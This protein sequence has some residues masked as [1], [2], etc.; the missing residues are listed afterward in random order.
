MFRR[1]Y[2]PKYEDGELKSRTNRQLEELSKGEN[3]DKGA[4]DK[5]A[6]SPGGN[7]G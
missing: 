1:I 2:S 3:M 7:E 6:G 5:V 4:K